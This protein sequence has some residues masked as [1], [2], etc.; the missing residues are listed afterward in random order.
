MRVADKSQN[1]VQANVRSLPGSIVA[2]GLA[3]LTASRNDADSL[4]RRGECFFSGR[5]G[6]PQDDE[7]AFRCYI[8]A[9]KLGH[10]ASQANVGRMYTHGL[11]VEKNDQNGRF[12][13]S[14]AA[15]SYISAAENG[16]ATAQY[17]TGVMY[18]LGRG[19]VEDFVQAK[20][21]FHKAAA[22]EHAPA[23][24][25]LA[26]MFSAGQGGPKDEKLAMHFNLLAAEQGDSHA[27]SWLAAAYSAGELVPKD[28]NRAAHWLRKSAAQSDATGQMGAGVA[29][30]KGDLV[31]QDD[32]EAVYWWRRGVEQ[33]HMRAV[34]RRLEILDTRATLEVY[35]TERVT[36]LAYC[37]Y[38][39][40]MAYEKG[41]GVPQDL[42]QALAWY[43]E[44]ADHGLAAAQRRVERLEPKTSP[45]GVLSERDG[46]GYK[47]E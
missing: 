38:F 13:D 18:L 33:G 11:G 17:L 39:L 31:P 29:F 26:K 27:Q 1:G 30:F 3:A 41:R 42:A 16:D 46:A 21:W 35:Q 36:S 10:A 12:W 9:A 14:Q 19:V 28:L 20:R 40:G 4:Y 2:R 23:Q 7:E 45:R 8:G 43:R 5:D 44:A 25:T 6:Y 37:E 24:A 15:A 47:P 32:V 22:Q 34:R